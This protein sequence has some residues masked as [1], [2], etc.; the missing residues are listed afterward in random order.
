[1]NARGIRIEC[2]GR[3]WWPSFAVNRASV[4][5]DTV[6]FECGLASVELTLDDRSP[7]TYRFVRIGDAQLTALT[8]NPAT[9][10]MSIWSAINANSNEPPIPLS[11]DH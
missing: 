10:E 2:A 7:M 3:I 9:S 1:V 6:T 5:R 8:E 11:I 4:T